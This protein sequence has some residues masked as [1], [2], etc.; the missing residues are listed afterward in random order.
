LSEAAEVIFACA[1]ARLALH[2]TKPV[3]SRTHRA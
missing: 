1:V 2:A 3:R